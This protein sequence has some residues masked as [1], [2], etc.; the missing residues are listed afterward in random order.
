MTFYC[1]FA[2]MLWRSIKIFYFS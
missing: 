2:V 1:M